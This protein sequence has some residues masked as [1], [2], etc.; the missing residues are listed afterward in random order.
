[1]SQPAVSM[2]KTWWDAA[3]TDWT[4][5][6]PAKVI[7]LF[8]QSYP[9]MSDLRRVAGA[10]GISCA[11]S[12]PSASAGW[13]AVFEAAAR[14]EN[15]GPLE[16]AAYLLF[17]DTPAR[18]AVRDMLIRL[19]GERLSHAHALGA[20]RYGRAAVPSATVLAEE[21]LEAITS[22]T[23]GFWDPDAYARALEDHRRRTALLRRGR[24]EAG[25]GVLIGPDL[26]LTAAHVL[27]YDGWPPPTPLEMHAVFDYA[28]HG[29]S[30]A[31]EGVRVKVAELVFGVP[32]TDAERRNEVTS[33]RSAPQ[34]HLDFAVVRLQR[35]IGREP[36]QD[37]RGYYQ[38][39][40]TPYAFTGRTLRLV[41]HPVGGVAKIS[42]VIGNVTPTDDRS[43]MDYQ[44]NSLAGSSG[45]P[46]VDADG[47]LVGIHH[48][49]PKHS[50]RGVP[51][52]TI[53]EVLL[54]SP[55]ASLFTTPAERPATARSS[56]PFLATVLADDPFVDRE[57]LRDA[58]RRMAKAN[59]K[60][61]LA[62]SGATEL[63][64][65]HSFVFLTHVADQSRKCEE[66][67]A[68]ANGG[69][70]PIV[71]DLRAFEGLPVDEQLPEVGKYLLESA[72]LWTETDEAAQRPR[73]AVSIANRLRSKISKSDEQW[74]ICFDS[75]DHPE[76]LTQS[77]LHELINAVAGL[78]RD[79]RLQVRVVLGGQRVREF[80]A[81]PTNNLPWVPHEVE[82]TPISRTHAAD[83]VRKRVQ[84]EGH[85]LPPG[86][87]EAEL[88][89]FIR[90]ELNL[91]YE[92]VEAFEHVG[93][94]PR[95]VADVLPAF[96]AKVST[97]NTSED[98]D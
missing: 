90:R 98:S 10:V 84:E 96:L 39:D 46:I 88:A 65:S 7:S 79:L 14:A 72:D 73:H 68:V 2:D 44:T 61:S 11:D 9:N 47:Y 81:E 86:D 34:T 31:E 21:P 20:I 63:G 71:V 48:A 89:A 13:L 37:P 95:D 45:G 57:P 66:L 3:T 97:T 33:G 32:P 85:A 59:G 30:P 82:V 55:Y 75:I 53:S 91:S 6:E 38:L 58:L 78:T 27:R 69:L 28:S 42:E 67:A 54:A 62:I 52:S 80:L 29:R 17:D 77:R 24:D 87:L 1:M 4:Q 60:R 16:L 64:K 83:W 49:G 51:F 40:R 94:P 36:D 19:L 23:A 15:H 70:K 43:R 41:H 35:P 25:T 18:V 8:K 12:A 26:L 76:S 93:W 22:R 50:G 92:E 56:S 5:G 74:W